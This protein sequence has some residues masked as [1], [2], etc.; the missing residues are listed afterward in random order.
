MEDTVGTGLSER[1]ASESEG[2]NKHHR[3]D[4]LT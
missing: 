4:G 2:R 1:Q 3:A